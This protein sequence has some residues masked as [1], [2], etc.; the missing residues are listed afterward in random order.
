[1]PNRS[2]TLVFM[3]SFDARKGF[4]RW[5]LP[6]AGAHLP[7]RPQANADLWTDRSGRLVARFS[8]AGHVCHYEIAASGGEPLG[9]VDAPA[10]NHFL[11][12][13]LVAWE[14]EGFDDDVFKL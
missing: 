1:M 13:K 8:G 4:K 12:D 7:A 3:D 10:M 9:E 6:G 2:F 14:I 11:Q 5:V